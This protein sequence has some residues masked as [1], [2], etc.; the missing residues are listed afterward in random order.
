MTP[1]RKLPLLLLVL[2]LLSI[3]TFAAE[4]VDVTPDNSVLLA[5]ALGQRKNFEESGLQPICFIK[6]HNVQTERVADGISYTYQI[7][8][9][10][11]FEFRGFGVCKSGG[12]DVKS[13]EVQV[14]QP[15]R[16]TSATVVR[17]WLI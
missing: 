15:T 3:Y 17:I 5:N 16:S 13:Y 9:C 1:F 10:E 6:I 8:G 11:V 7:Q 14:F 12:C 4:F 2:L